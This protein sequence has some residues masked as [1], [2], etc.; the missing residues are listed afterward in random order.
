MI[1]KVPLTSDPGKEKSGLWKLLNPQLCVFSSWSSIRVQTAKLEQSEDGDSER[2]S[3]QRFGPL[4]P[5]RNG[6]VSVASLLRRA[7]G[8]ELLVEVSLE[9]M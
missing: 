2:E 8:W 5:I 7:L 4:N 1:A 3:S 9:R 6:A